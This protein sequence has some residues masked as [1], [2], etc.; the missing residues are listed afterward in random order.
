[1]D[2]IV[3]TEADTAEI[4]PDRCIGCGLCVTTCPAEA[5]ELLP[6][7][8]TDWRTPPSNTAEQMM[9]MARKRGII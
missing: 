2:A 9:R 8:E 6:K 1:M 5:I 3:M 7:S 4:N